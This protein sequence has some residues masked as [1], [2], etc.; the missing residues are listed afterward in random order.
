MTLRRSVF[1]RFIGLLALLIVLVC[2]T[3]FVFLVGRHRA[4]EKKQG[5]N[6]TLI[7]ARDVERFILWND[8]VRLR[9]VLDDT[10]EY[11]DL[12]E[13]A[14]IERHARPYI[15][16][17]QKGVPESLIRRH[18]QIPVGVARVVEL[19]NQKGE[20]FYDVAATVEG[21]DAI[22]HLGLSRRVIDE[23]IHASLGMILAVG[24]VVLLLGSCLAAAISA[25]I[26]REVDERT[27]ELE[28]EIKER[29]Q[30]EGFLAIAHRN[31]QNVLDASSEVSIIATD[32]Q[33]LITVFNMGAERMLGYTAEEMVGKQTPTI[34][35]LE[36]EVIAHGSELSEEFGTPIEGFEVFVAQ[37][38]RG[39]HEERHWTY[40]RKDG[41]HLTV[42]LAVTAVRN[43]S[44]DVTGLL[45]VALDVTEEK[46]AEEA[47]ASNERKL[48]T[49]T[50]SALDAVIMVDPAGNIAHWNPAAETIFGYSYEEMLGQQVHKILAPSRYREA[51]SKGH[52][53]FMSSGQGAA[54]G[55]TLELA[56]LRKDGTEF[57]IEIS[58]NS[59]E[60][61]DGWWAVA[62]LRDITERKQAEQQAED[63]AAALKSNNLVLEELNRSV[64]AAD[65]AKSE[66]LA[67]MSHEIRTP[68]TAILGFSDVLLGNLDEEEVENFSAA[69]TIKRNG[70]YLL[71]LINDILDLSKIEAGRLEA[72]RIACSPSNVV[73]DVASL[74][75]VRA[76]AKGLPLRIEYVGGIPETIQCDPT[77]LRQILINLVGNAIKFTESGSVR[78]VSRLVQGTARPPSM[79]FDVIDTGIG[80]TQGQ[81]SKLFQPFMQA[82]ASTSRKFGGT[83]LG[84]TISKRLAKVL[85]GDIAISSSP[86]KGST[87]SV[88][89]ETGP[90]DGVAILENVTE[91]VA[92]SR[93]KVE[94][95]DA[96]AVK[97][98]CR[99]LLAEDGPDNQRLI[100]F[101]LKKAGAKVTLAE[102]G[103]IAHDKALAARE[104]GEPFDVILMDMQ[105]PIM[106]G[107][108]AT[109]KL[110]QAGY[111]GPIVALT[112]NAMAGDD[113][114]CREAGCDG[115]ATK[116]IDRAKL[117]A[118]I[119][120]S[121]G[122]DASAREAL[123]G[124]DA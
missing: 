12:F 123:A 98:G 34:L 5:R 77:R 122:Q 24:T 119:A 10:V 35:H 6:H 44:G 85:G 99:I 116:P 66:F 69:T 4:F 76:E 15:H 13:Y 39:G 88:T 96:P 114:K 32:S 26:V 83:G 111:T 11:V 19:R 91:A 30:A 86:G 29:K 58:L 49:I 7:L 2:V 37:A 42:N 64:E 46:K 43:D 89:V 108:T 67:N 68:M 72:E 50:D 106:D 101:V 75:R 93:R 3:M 27:R 28:S 41:S 87:F 84:L 45:S 53:H 23:E 55:K 79:Q 113:E 48:R 109:R 70:K 40:V 25:R 60:Q 1:L 59:I 57:P 102:N 14:F 107:Y 92:E 112:A 62:V 117:F 36:S 78:L 9:E 110:R 118:T 115:Y 38:R 54:I 51:A 52:L 94:V 104:A 63:Y 103:L 65:R 97:L 81:A 31:L 61:D 100:S 8:R 17:F 74:M 95:A 121:L 120:Q 21:T 105:M 82:D 33:G 47:L 20:V 18:E 124:N 73:A 71:D 16:T 22:I 90:L 56:A 80:M